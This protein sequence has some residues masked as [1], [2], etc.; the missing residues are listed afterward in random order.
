M[1]SKHK[2]WV[3]VSLIMVIGYVMYQYTSKTMLD[4]NIKVIHSYQE[5]IESAKEWDSSTLVLFDVDDTLIYGPYLFPDGF[6]NQLW[7]RIRFLLRYPWLVSPPLFEEYY[8]LMWQQAKRVVVEPEVV[9]LIQDLHKNGAMVIGLT[10]METGSYGVIESL[11]KWRADMLTDFGITFTRTFEN[12][13]FSALKAYRSE[14]PEL[15][16]GILCCNWQ[17]KSVVVGAFLDKY[18]LKPSKIVFF[19][20]QY[21]RVKDI[22]DFCEQQN[23]PFE[24]YQYLG[25]DR[26]YP[27]WDMQK[28]LAQVDSL[29]QHRTWLAD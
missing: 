11:P 17:P 3:V 9:P 12:T 27:Q 24:V 13:T 10:A 22:A 20:D 16:E 29:V 2:L 7:F 8:S 18:H 25:A 4:K 14:Y 15:Y 28:A 6:L 26:L 1:F 5:I 21:S 19:D 23:I